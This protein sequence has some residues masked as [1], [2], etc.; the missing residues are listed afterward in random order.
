MSNK[1]KRYDAAMAKYDRSKLYEPAEALQLVKDMAAA[2]FDET[3]ELSVLLGL[4]VRKADQQV[5]GTVSLPKGTGKTLRVAVF[6]QAERAREAEEA[7]A[8]VVGDKDLAERIEKGWTDFDIAIATPDMMPVVGKLGKILG[9]RGLMPNPK[10][11]T[12]TTDVAKT[13]REFKAGKIE[14]KTDRQANVHTII[15]KAS[16]PVEDLAANYLTVM[17]E[18]L[19]AKP[20]AAK[21]KYIKTMAVSSTMSPGVRIDPTA[22]KKLELA[23]D[24]G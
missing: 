6:A 7:G 3:V 18:I 12:V 2:K 5:R 1:G 20:S 15:G 14:Y 23:G 21:G 4:D 10:S 19:R 24:A 13:V 22:A 11:G 8:D 9:P 17:D 16:F